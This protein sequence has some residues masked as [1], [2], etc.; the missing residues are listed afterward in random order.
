MIDRLLAEGGR[1]DF[2]ERFLVDAGHDWAAGLA[3][4]YNAS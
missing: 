2:L 1:I 3:S 4:E